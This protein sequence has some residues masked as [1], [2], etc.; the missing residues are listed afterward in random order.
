[1]VP[2]STGLVGTQTWE[3]FNA[4]WAKSRDAD[5]FVCA[6]VEELTG[7]VIS[8]P[9]GC[10]GCVAAYSLSATELDGDCN[11]P[12]DTDPSYTG[13]VSILG[14]GDVS[15]DIESLDRWPGRS[16]GW[17]IS[18]DHGETLTPYGF[19]WDEALDWQGDLGTPGWV[20]DQTYT[21]WPAY[22][23]DLRD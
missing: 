6:R 14:V 11:A 23:W 9:D 13:G 5:D 8:P 20:N 18:E 7:E 15:A 3:F 17:Y 2:T 19:A 12:L 22:A 1:V 21:L 10:D 16:L 4:D